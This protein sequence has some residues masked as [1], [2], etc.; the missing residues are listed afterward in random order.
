MVRNDE[1]HSLAEVDSHRALHPESLERHQALGKKSR[2]EVKVS[3]HTPAP[4]LSLLL[5][6]KS[7]VSAPGPAPAPQPEEAGVTGK[8]KCMWKAVNPFLLIIRCSL[9]GQEV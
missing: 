8:A 3:I 9:G 5:M 1:V 4:K 2:K 7:V 6:T